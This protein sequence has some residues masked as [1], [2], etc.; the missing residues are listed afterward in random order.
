[1]ISSMP[2]FSNLLG[3]LPWEPLF[4]WTSH[5]SI[6]LLDSDDNDSS[7]RTYQSLHPSPSHCLHHE[8]LSVVHVVSNFWLLLPK[9]VLNLAQEYCELG[10]L[11][12]LGVLSHADDNNYFEYLHLKVFQHNRFQLNRI[13]INLETQWLFSCLSCPK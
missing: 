11:L 4:L 9:W 6:S 5:C 8:F 3:V 7:Q 10:N 1:M 12:F 2:L 13:S